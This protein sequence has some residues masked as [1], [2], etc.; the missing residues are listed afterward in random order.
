LLLTYFNQHCFNVYW[1]D[2]NYKK[3][4]NNNFMVYL[5]GYGL[6]FV[7]KY[8]WNKA[9]ER[10]IPIDIIFN[11][12]LNNRKEIGQG[13]SSDI[14]VDKALPIETY[15]NGY[16]YNQSIDHLIKNET[17]GLLFES[18]NSD[19]LA[20]KILKIYYD[21]KYSFRLAENIY[22]KFLAGYKVQ[23]IIPKFEKL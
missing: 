9:C 5:D 23:N 13:F 8:L 15:F 17:E 19:D 1:E 10:F 3:N 14:L 4:L 7:L 21:K 2:K 20:S 22:S 18:G 6:Y 16:E 12:I 11:I